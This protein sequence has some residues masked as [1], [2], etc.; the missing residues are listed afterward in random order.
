MEQN[1]DIAQAG[2]S[3]QGETSSGERRPAQ[4]S[5]F[6]SA[7]TQLARGKRPIA[8]STGIA[9]LIGSW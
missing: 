3:Q 9:F 7:L 6:F 8:L 4:G 1:P 2:V 5:A